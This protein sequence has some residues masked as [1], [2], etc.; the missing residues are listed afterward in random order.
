M[1][2]EQAQPSNDTNNT[3]H[4]QQEGKEFTPITSQEVLDKIIGERL[5]RE[6][7]KYADYD[8]LKTKAAQYDEQVE[9]SK[10]AEEK[11]AEQIAKLQAE[12]EQLKTAQ[13]RTQV[14]AE[15]NVPVELLYGTTREELEE[16]ASQLLTWVDAKTPAPSRGKVSGAASS[17]K[18]TPKADAAALL[19]DFMGQR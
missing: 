13:L 8:E 19:R 16:Q 2:N 9:A 7:N 17:T 12:N 1:P 15:K 6:R 4:T 10:T 3:N 14:A 5:A 11:T 18:H